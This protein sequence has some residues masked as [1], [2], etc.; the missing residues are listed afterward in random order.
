MKQHIIIWDMSAERIHA[1]QVSLYEAIH[2]LGIDA[3]V[4]FNSEEPLLSRN[5]LLGRTPAVQVNGYAQVWTCR[6]NQA[7]GTADFVSLF[8]YLRDNHFMEF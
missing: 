7:I 3:S 2:Q 6:V 4:Q 8:L 5:G 1:M